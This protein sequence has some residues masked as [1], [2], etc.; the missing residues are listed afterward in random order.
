MKWEVADHDFA[1]RFLLLYFFHITTIVLL[2]RGS[3]Y[4]R[5]LLPLEPLASPSAKL[6]RALPRLRA[7]P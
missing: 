3:Q 5:S 4:H 7:M 1:L 2:I 6:Y